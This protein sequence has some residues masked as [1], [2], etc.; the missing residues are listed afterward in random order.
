M[1]S[2]ASLIELS[3]YGG[4][5]EGFLFEKVYSEY[6]Q[7]PLQLRLV[8]LDYNSIVLVRHRVLGHLLAEGLGLLQMQRQF[9]S[10]F[11]HG[12]LGAEM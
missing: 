9:V 1:G 5:C 12:L 7:I 4:H 8:V 6:S 2:A 10:H 11:V 3:V